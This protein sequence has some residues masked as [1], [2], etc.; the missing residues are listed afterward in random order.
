MIKGIIRW[1]ILAAIIMALPYII[2]DL[3]VAT[4]TTALVAAAVIGLINTF[5]KPILKLLTLP[6]RLL[7]LG[8]FGFVLNVFLFWLSSILVPGFEIMSLSAGIIGA[9]IMAIALWILDKVF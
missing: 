3:V 8:L 4:T 5:I 6:I 1:V 2:P 9:F 7:T